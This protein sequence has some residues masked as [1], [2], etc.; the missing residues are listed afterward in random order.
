MPDVFHLYDTMQRGERPLVAADPSRVTFYTCGPT[1]YDDA[2]IGNFRAFLVAD[3]LRRWLESPLCTLA[4]EGGEHHRGPRTVD[5]RMNITDVGHMTEDEAADGGGEDK[6]ALASRRLAEAKKSGTLPPGTEDVD[7]SDP[8]AVADFFR[9][10]FIEDAS[11][12]GIRVAR[13]AGQAPDRMPRATD[14]IGDMIE[15]VRALEDRGFAYVRGE[16]GER[17]V[18]FDVQKFERYGALSGNDLDQLRG[19]AGGRV[20]DKAQAQKNHPADFM[21][22]KEDP[23]HI[24]RWESPW[25]AGYPGWHIECSAMSLAALLPGGLEA[26]AKGNAAIERAIDLHSGG[27]DNIFPHH[28]CEIAQSCAFT[29]AERFARH[30]VHVRFLMVNGEKMSKSRGTFFAPRDLMH[31]GHDPAAVRFELIKTHYR[32]NADFSLEELRASS[33]QVERWRRFLRA[34]DASSEEG[35]RS[36]EAADRFTACLA[37]DLNVAGAIGEVNRWIGATRSPTRADAALM[38]EFDAVLGL[39]ELERLESRET[40]IGVFKGVKPD[41]EVERLLAERAEARKAKDF[42]RADA[43]RDDLSARGLAIKDAPGGKVEVSPA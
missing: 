36:T 39:L 4:T 17:V 35:D 38:R 40:T 10:R 6:M 15:L 1:V 3:L 7:P 43:I 29:G 26:I 27:E 22:W 24:M 13:E 5:H 31:R 11:K 20:T 41:P 2:H 28:E 21:L 30:W 12:L 37:G 33:Q 25:G 16:P 23:R 34:A 8:H 14:H 42:A 18:Y 19:G 32:V 9:R